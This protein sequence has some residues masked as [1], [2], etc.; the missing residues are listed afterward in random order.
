VTD[1]PSLDPTLKVVLD[2][3]PG[4]EA[5]GP[6][7]I[8]PLEGG[9]TNRNFL[10][11]LGDADAYVVRLPGKDTG[12]LGI[13]RNHERRATEIAASLGV[14]PDVIAF[15]PDLGCLVTRFIDARPVPAESMASRGTLDLVVDSIHRLHRG[16]EIP[17]FFSPFRVVEDYAE[18]AS[19]R[20]VQLP[21]VYAWLLERAHQIESAFERN[22][23]PLNPC[24]NDLLNANFL[25]TGDRI[26]IVDYEYAGMGDLFFDL[27]N[28]SINHDFDDDAD[29]LL[30][31][32][33]F[34]AAEDSARARLKLMRIMSDFREAM[35]G[36]LQQAVSKLDFDYVEYATK[37][38]ERCK[39]HIDD[40]RYTTWLQD[41]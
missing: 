22:P 37:H 2:S 13:D 26:Y 1:A 11:K 39:S 33:Y 17:G 6:L 3:I 30:L 24:H 25:Q 28:L 10:V 27:G 38:F 15:V 29:E 20:G 18:L 36:V 35:W 12:L 40:D 19:S 34:E 16:P 31:E 9:I 4:L 8:S 5:S 7:D 21:E 32:L 41:A 23:Q 14:G